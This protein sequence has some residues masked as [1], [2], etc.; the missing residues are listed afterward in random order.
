MDSFEHYAGTLHAKNLDTIQVNT[1]LLCNQACTHCHLRCSP[2]RKE[3]MDWETM[4]LVLDL[5]L[6]VSAHTLDITGGAPELN[7][8]L[9]QFI[10]AAKDKGLTL[11][12]HTNLTAQGDNTFWAELFA[13]NEVELVASL[14]CYEEENV[15]KVRG[16]NTFSQSIRVLK[17]LNSLGY[18]QDANLKLNLMF[19]PGGATLPPCQK[20]LEKSYK[21]NMH[22]KY[23]VTFTNLLTLCN[24]PSGRFLE[25]LQKTGE[26]TNYIKLLTQTFNPDTLPNLMCR[27][28]INIG[29]D[30]TL[31]DCDFNQ[32]L[33][34]PLSEENSH[35]STCNPNALKT[36]KIA[37]GLH[38]LACTAGAGSSC[39]GEL[40]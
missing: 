19:N 10:P 38:C 2:A 26:Y 28:L 37:T 30:G 11:R 8:L 3:L 31:Y 9:E 17:V 4:S 13:K 15:D 32:A 6:A 18:G 20:D 33:R 34:L 39:S 22:K 14:P 35:I 25:Y 29:Y 1:G 27:G 12:L 5:A 7:P 21:K 36:R 16:K 40:L 23:G 24:S